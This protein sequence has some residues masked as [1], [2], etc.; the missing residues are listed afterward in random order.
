MVIVT[1]SIHVAADRLTEALALSLEHVHRSRLEPGCVSHGVSQDVEDPN[2]VIF[3]E[4]WADRA[5]LA[6]HFGIPEARAFSRAIGAMAV[7]PAQ[8]TLYDAEEFRP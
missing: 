3:V 8:M 7:E 1:A 5:A 6:V 2:H 4:R